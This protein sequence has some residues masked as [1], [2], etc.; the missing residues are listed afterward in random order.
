MDTAF[1]LIVIGAGPG[2]YVAAI[3][4]AQLGM[5]TALCEERDVG[6]TCLNRG[7]I[8]TKTLLHSANLYRAICEAGMFGVSADGVH[9]DLSA[10]YTRKNEVV[11]QLR[12]GI[13]TLLKQNKVQLIRGKAVITGQGIVQAGETRLKADKILIA[14]GSAPAVP[15]IP[16]IHLSMTSDDLLEAAAPLDE[17]AIIGGG[18]IGVEFASFYAALG[19]KV[20]IIEAMDRILPSFD[21]EI[22]QNLAMIL[23]RQGVGVQIET[24]AHVTEISKTQSD[25]L[26]CRYT[27]RNGEMSASVDRVLCAA[28]RRAQT[29]GLCADGFSLETERGYIV[30]NSA[31]ETSVPGICAIGDVIGGVQLAH[32]AS[33]Q[34]IAA[35]EGMCRVKRTVRPDVIPSCVYTTPEIACVG[36]TADEAK[37]RGTAVKTGKFLLTASGKALIEHSERSFIKLVFDAKTDVVLGAQMMCPR[38]TDLIGEMTNAVVQGLTKEQLLSVVRPHP[39]FC[40]AVTEAAEAADGKSIHSAPSRK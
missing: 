13:E 18:V 5:R 4:A 24:G 21:R 14:S 30:V 35:V 25:K 40:E 38:A 15:S 9:Y 26:C 27:S 3:R 19:K 32:A 23:K 17:L 28:G 36:W 31:F 33:A 8:P 29:Q 37:A 12:S 2:G 1:D 11:T 7:C 34:G 10:V 6:G 22:S 39:T 20:L 16:G